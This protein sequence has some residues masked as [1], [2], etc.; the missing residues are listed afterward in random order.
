MQRVL[1]VLCLAGG[2]LFAEGFMRFEAALSRPFGTHV[3]LAPRPPVKMM[4]NEGGYSEPFVQLARAYANTPVEFEHLKAVTLAMM[5]LESG[6]GGSDL[7]RK[8]YN[9]GGLKYRPEM[10]PFASKVRYNASDGIDH[11]CKFDSVESFIGG[12]WA[13]LDRRPYQGWRSKAASE[14]AF[15]EF[16]APIY[17]PFNPNYADH[18]MALV[19]EAK[20]LLNRYADDGF[21]VA[22][23]R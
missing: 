6:R 13:F 19:P 10:Q 1:L 4:P 16:I 3:H 14:R 8:H 18:V 2:T 20:E 21:R 15:I 11:Y 7:A 22:M 9:F 17:C 12:F 23:L 5:I